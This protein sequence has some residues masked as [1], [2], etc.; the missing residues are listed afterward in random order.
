MSTKAAPNG[1]PQTSAAYKA[2]AAGQVAALTALEDHVRPTPDAGAREGEPNRWVALA[3][4]LASFFLATAALPL[5][6]ARYFLAKPA[7]FNSFPGYVL[8]RLIGLTLV[9]HR[10]MPPIEDQRKRARALQLLPFRGLDKLVKVTQVTIPPVS[11]A[12]RRTRPMPA[13]EVEGIPLPGYMLSPPGTR[14]GVARA[15]P[16]EKLIV[17]LHG[18]WVWCCGRA[19]TRQRVRRRPPPVPYVPVQDRKGHPDTAVW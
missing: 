17:Y 15:A 7:G 2:A 18:G 13:P 12:V 5:L 1:L 16:G 14:Q 6:A 11:D 19:L 10:A 4:L 3:W 8:C 9:T